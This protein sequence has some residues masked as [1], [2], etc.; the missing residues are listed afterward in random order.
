MRAHAGEGRLLTHDRDNTLM[1]RVVKSTT[2][3]P[4]CPRFSLSTFILHKH[5]HQNNVVQHPHP[6]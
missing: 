3:A 4:L 1:D 2:G 5:E 6:A